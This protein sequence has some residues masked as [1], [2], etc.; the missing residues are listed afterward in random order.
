MAEFFDNPTKSVF[1][2]YEGANSEEKSSS[3]KLRRLFHH[4]LKSVLSPL[5]CSMQPANPFPPS[6]PKLSIV[7]SG[8]P[9]SNLFTSPSSRHLV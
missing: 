3:F 8:M 9:F 1:Q 4:H 6:L 5:E 7:L 2:F